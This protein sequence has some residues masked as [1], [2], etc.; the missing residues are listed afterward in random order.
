MSA[1][2]DPSGERATAGEP[3]E[4][5][6]AVLGWWDEQRA[7]L[8]EALTAG[9]D[10]PAFLPFRHYP[11]TIA[12]WAR[13]QAHELAIHRLDAELALGPE[14][15]TFEPGFAADG[16]DEFLVRLLPTLRKWA[17]STADGAVLVR[18][19]D[20]ERAW[21]VRLAPGAPPVVL[22]VDPVPEEFDP[23]VT[24]EG[25]A[26]A[27]YR[28]VWGRPHEATITGDERLLEPLA[29]P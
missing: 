2:A 1:I 20:V 29:A 19:T 12:S 4:D 6:D 3:P 10:A 17:E 15:E 16:A 24:V 5:W 13:R 25:T 7:A 26:D 8:R 18:P 23:D 28:A 21:T 9:P 14:T 27:V 22:A 11:P